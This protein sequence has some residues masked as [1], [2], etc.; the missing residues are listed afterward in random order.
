MSGGGSGQNGQGGGQ[1]GTGDQSGD[2]TTGQVSENSAGEGSTSGLE[3]NEQT[4][5]EALTQKGQVSEITGSPS[6]KTPRGIIAPKDNDKIICKLLFQEITKTQDADML[7]GLKEQ[8][9][10]YQCG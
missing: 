5:A 7:K 9:Q 1:S 4:G 3:G 6:S 2:G 10:N 8:Y